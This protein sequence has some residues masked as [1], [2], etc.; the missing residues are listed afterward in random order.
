[1]AR[2]FFVPSFLHSFFK[3]KQM[4]IWNR[5]RAHVYASDFSMRFLRPC[6]ISVLSEWLQFYWVT[7]ARPWSSIVEGGEGSFLINCQTNLV[8]ALYT[9]SLLFCKFINTTG[10]HLG[11]CEPSSPVSCRTPWLGS[12]FLL[13]TLIFFM[14]LGKPTLR[15]ALQ[16]ILGELEFKKLP[17]IDVA[18]FPTFTGDPWI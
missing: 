13:R 12:Q 5:R 7:R 6:A 4:S 17:N 14:S 8:I 11:R 10:Y 2:S 9:L 16:A 3:H 15:Q 1:M 18:S